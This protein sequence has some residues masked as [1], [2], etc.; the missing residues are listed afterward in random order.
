[1]GAMFA[2]L[3][4]F[5]TAVT[6]FFS[7]FEKTAKAVEHLATWSEESAGAFADQARIDRADKLMEMQA[8]SG[9]KAKALS[10]P[11]AAA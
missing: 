2:A 5:F 1:M 4:Q 8:A 9:V 7:A 3:N 10:A 11:K 6:V